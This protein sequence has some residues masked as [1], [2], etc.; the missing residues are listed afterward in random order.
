MKHDWSDW[1]I[2]GKTQLRLIPKKHGIYEFRCVDENRSPI[3][4][5]RLKGEDPRGVVY[6]GSSVNL[7]KRINGFWKTIQNRNESRHAAGWTYCS[8]RYDTVF[9]P[10]RLQFRYKLVIDTVRN[11]FDL[12]L[13]YRKR[14]MDLPPLN[15]TPPPYPRDWKKRIEKG[16]GS[17][18][19][20]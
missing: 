13:E 4:V 7:K 11:E 15:S 19:L 16:F 5:S 10:E 2:F 20:A 6:I 12:L 3:S 18:P 1:L 9:P 8:F 14:F 17:R